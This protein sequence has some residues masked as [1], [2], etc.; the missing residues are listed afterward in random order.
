MM[1]SLRQIDQQV[2]PVH[3][4]ILVDVDGEAKNARGVWIHLRGEE[5]G[6]EVLQYYIR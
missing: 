2:S 1:T 5:R 6:V 3:D 4:S